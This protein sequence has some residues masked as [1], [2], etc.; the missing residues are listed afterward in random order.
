MA[1]EP[2]KPTSRIKAATATLLYWAACA[3]ASPLYLVPAGWREAM[4]RP[5]GWVMGRVCSGSQRSIRSEFTS[6]MDRRP[7][8]YSETAV[9][10]ELFRTA[11]RFG[12]DAGVGLLSSPDKIA[13]SYDPLD[14][15]AITRALAA[16]PVNPATGR[17]Q[18]AILAFLH[19]GTFM[20][21]APL[22]KSKG[23]ENLAVVTIYPPDSIV[24]TVLDKIA[25]KHGFEIVGVEPSAGSRRRVIDKC[26][27]LV[28][29]GKLV[30]IAGDVYLSR[31]GATSGIPVEYAGK[32]RLVGRAIPAVALATGAPIVCAATYQNGKSRSARVSSVII[33]PSRIPKTQQ[34]QRYIAQQVADQM[35]ALIAHSPGQWFEWGTVRPAA[36]GLLA[37]LRKGTGV[38]EKVI[39]P[40]EEL[41]ARIAAT[42]NERTFEPGVTAKPVEVTRAAAPL[43]S[44]VP[45][46]GSSRQ[47]TP[48][49]MDR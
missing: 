48:Q 14:T 35:D 5:L 42:Y 3:M 22:L 23:F 19:S 16:S 29:Q 34:P 12:I 11:A 43:V 26:I 44:E 38:K 47:L 45:R 49:Q 18:G 10:K 40:S 39:Q 41:I 30:A 9:E 36:S 8:I 33:D 17:K 7:D 4:V 46:V 1:V 21:A 37:K 13:E 28:Q 2:S 6:A 31:P 32:T 20:L 24:S 27:E 25:A 15:S